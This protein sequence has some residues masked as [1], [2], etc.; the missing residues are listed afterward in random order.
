MNRLFSFIVTLTAT[1]FGAQVQG[2]KPYIVGVL[3]DSVSAGFNALRY[4]D[5]REF[6]WAGGLD[7]Q[8]QVQSHARKLQHLMP[9]RQIEVHN[10]AFVGADSKNMARQTARLLRVSPDYVTIGMG[11]NDVCEWSEDYLASLGTYEAS[12]VA[13]IEKIIAKNPDVK[14]VLA[15]VPSLRLMYELG[16]QR[17]GCQDK[18]ETIGVCRPLLASGLTGED[19][20]RFFARHQHLNQVIESTATRFARNV[21]FAHALADTVFEQSS[22]SPL[23]CF[24]PSISGQNL[25]SDQSFDPSWY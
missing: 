25:I 9:L 19:R 10:E 11:A 23:D 16:R 4:G 7:S 14:I 12:L 3:G 8:F 6:S 17:S 18:W 13:A 24:H 2:A 5:N 21:K 20:E 22:V 1:F 15:P